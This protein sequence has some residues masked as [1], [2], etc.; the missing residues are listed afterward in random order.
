MKNIKRSGFCLFLRT[1]SKFSWMFFVKKGNFSENRRTLNFVERKLV[2][3]KFIFYKSFRK[4][5]TNL[6]EKW[7]VLVGANYLLWHCIY[8]LYQRPMN[9][10]SAVCVTFAIF[11]KRKNAQLKWLSSFPKNCGRKLKQAENTSKSTVHLLALKFR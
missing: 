8:V 1:R 2:W 4:H 3:K 5:I 6:W 10:Q 11:G 7:W 9:L